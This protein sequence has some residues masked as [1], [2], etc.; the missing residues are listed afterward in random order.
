MAASKKTI[1]RYDGMF[2]YMKKLEEE[3][4]FYM[5]DYRDKK[6]IKHVE[7]LK[8]KNSNKK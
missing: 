1:D 6:Y 7:D 3:Q 2:E 4:K 8:D 5:F